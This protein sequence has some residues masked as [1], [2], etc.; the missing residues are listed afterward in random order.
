MISGFLVAAL[1][2]IGSPKALAATCVPGTVTCCFSI[3]QEFVQMYVNEQ[4]ITHL[5]QPADGYANTSVVKTVTFT[6]PSATNVTIAIKGKYTCC[7]P[8]F[9]ITCTSTR[10]DSPWNNVEATLNASTPVGDRWRS[11]LS[12]SSRADAFPSDWYRHDYNE[13]AAIVYSVINSTSLIPFPSFP[14]PQCKPWSRRVRAQRTNTFFTFRRYVTQSEVCGTPSPTLDPTPAPS[15][16]PST[17][18]PSLAPT[19]SP[20]TTQP[21]SAPTCTRRVPSNAAGLL[22]VVDVSSSMD[23]EWY[24]PTLRDTITQIT[25]AMAPGIRSGLITF[26]GPSNRTVADISRYNRT[27]HQVVHFTSN[28]SAFLDSAVSPWLQKKVGG[29]S[30][31]PGV[32]EFVRDT[33]I[34]HALNDGPEL[35]DI[36]VVLVSDGK[37][38]DA[39]GRPSEAFTA[40]A[41][42]RANELLATGGPNLAIQLVYV[43]MHFLVYEPNALFAGS[44][45]HRY[46]ESV[47]TLG[48]LPS[49]FLCELPG[50]K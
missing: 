18:R 37:P 48:T 50:P 25:W 42:Q 46:D 6:E 14:A 35:S 22:W 38:T 24:Y 31:L 34:P 30:D 29:T 5:V 32:L 21:S 40:L 20:V 11:V 3:E 44:A 1:L 4:D 7:Q 47:S 23:G 41:E 49:R 45:A 36:T 43:Q 13:S 17:P 19:Q 16:S 12:T 10:L 26:S 8:S 33:Y 27:V 2:L 39:S 9:A 15:R 28:A